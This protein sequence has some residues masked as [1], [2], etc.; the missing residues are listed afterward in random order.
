MIFFGFYPMVDFLKAVTG[1]EMEVAEVLETGARIQT[2]R[3]AFNLRE[4][5][6][7]SDI[8]LPPRMAGIPP[9]NE[10]PLTGVTIDIDTLANE[11]RKAMGWDPETGQPTDATLDRLGL[12]ELTENC[13]K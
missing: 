8:K 6:K 11:Y 10:G 4:G 12:K 3:Q 2:L 9:K 13:W 7:A 5:I 1:W